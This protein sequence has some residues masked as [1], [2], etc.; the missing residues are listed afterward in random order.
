MSEQVESQD[1]ISQ[2]S[3]KVINL[4]KHSRSLLTTNIKES[5]KQTAKALLLAKQN[6]DQVNI[7]RVLNLYADIF[8]REGK[9]EKSFKYC[10]RSLKIS[11]T[12]GNKKSEATSCLMMGVTFWHKGEPEKAILHLET[13]LKLYEELDD[14]NG[15]AGV[16]NNLSLVYWDTGRLEAALKYHE[17]CLEIEKQLGNSQA[18]GIA[19]LNLGL[20]YEDLGDWDKSIECF[21]RA[22]VEKERNQDRAGMVLCYNNIGE[23]YLKRRRFDKALK[24]FKEAVR[25]ADETN[26]LQNKSEALGNIGYVYF[27]TGDVTSAITFYKEDIA[28]S[29]KL[30]YKVELAEA[31][32][33]MAELLILTDPQKCRS[34]L[35]KAQRLTYKTGSKKELADIKRVF[36]KFYAQTANHTEAEKSFK[37]SIEILKAMG[38]GYELAEVYRDYGKYLV[39]K[40]EKQ[41]GIVYL[42]ESAKIFDKLDVQNESETIESFLIQLEGEK[43]KEFSL[44]KKISSFSNRKSDLEEFT[45]DCLK[46]FH[47]TLKFQDGIFFI[48]GHKPSIIGRISANEAMQLNKKSTIQAT[49]NLILLPVKSDGENFGF[50]CFKWKSERAF[51]ANPNFWEI[52][53]NIISLGLSK[54]RI[55][56]EMTK[57]Q[58]GKKFPFQGIIGETITLKEIFDIIEKTAPTNACVLIQGESGTGKELM[59]KTIHE[60]S[61]R[62]DKP[63]VTINCSAIPENLLESELFG[64]EK[65]TATGVSERQG[66][67]EQANTGTIFLDEIGDMSLPLQSKILRVLQEKTFERVGGRKPIIVDIRV[68]AATNK[69]LAQEIKQGNF[70]EDLYHRLNVIPIFLPPLRDRKQDIPLLV[71]HF[72]QKFSQEFCRPINGV[73]GDVLQSFLTYHWPGNV[74]ELENTLERLVILAKNNLISHEDLPPQFKQTVESQTLAINSS[75]SLKELRGKAKE[76]SLIPLERD[77]IIKSL[78]E[79]KYNILKAANAAG[80]S[81][82][83]FYRLMKKYRIE[84]RKYK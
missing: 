22:L 48:F 68:I 46:L 69:D 16:Y 78:V 9:F 14:K 50:L 10:Q 41:E 76:T 74:R 2:N 3:E 77:F 64:I 42:N 26:S 29:L 83:H 51:S 15:I 55:L 81:R 40:G 71:E 62:A 61:A 44:L 59:A 84:R 33:R 6:N 7:C 73:S 58:T 47:E 21:F 12:I 43:E 35:F 18:V 37:D 30:D 60:M 80:I 67:F 45:S 52:T 66:K 28:I 32:R 63:I 19:H 82:V 4:I 72:I 11:Q 5:R 1:K 27:L 53:S 57:K 79:H 49:P 54:I 34:L 31:F 17:L 23:I 13:A 38:K 65:G 24:F 39:E 56:S 20:I 25:L 75:K 36:G 8:R 70:R